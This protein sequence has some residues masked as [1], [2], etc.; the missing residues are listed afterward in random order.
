MKPLLKLEKIS[1]VYTTNNTVA[2]GLRNIDLEFNI[3]EFVTITGSSGSGKTTL[4]NVISGIDTYEEGEL[5]FEGNST[6]HFTQQE[7]EKY[8]IENISFIFQDYNILDSFTVLENVEF[9]LLHIE[10]P[11][12][13]RKKAVELIK[14]VGLYSHLNHKGSKLSGGQKQRTVI[15][16]AL[17]K[18][19]PIILADEPTG[20]LDSKSAKEIVQLLKDISDEKLVIVVTHNAEQ[21]SDVATR[22]IRLFDGSV[23]DDEEYV[24]IEPRECIKIEQPKLKSTFLSG[25]LLGIKRFKSRPKFTT[26]IV[27]MLFVAIFFSFL[28][29]ASE[30]YDVSSS[31]NIFNH[32]DG[33]VV[34]AKTDG[35][36]I[37]KEDLE[38]ISNIKDYV[39]DDNVLELKT[40][41]RFMDQALD[42]NNYYSFTCNYDYTGRI[43]KGRIPQNDNEVFLCVP[44]VCKD[45]CEQ[46]LNKTI[47]IDNFSFTLVGFKTYVDNTKDGYIY[48]T[49]QGFNDMSI[50][51]AINKIYYNVDTY[52]S[53]SS[54]NA[55]KP[56]LSL[57][58]TEVKYLQVD[59]SLNK[60]EI[61]VPNKF[62]IISVEDTSYEFN[63]NSKTI[64]I[65]FD[66]VIK[67]DVEEIYISLEDAYE[68]YENN[69]DLFKNTQ[70]SIFYKNDLEAKQHLQELV[71][72]GYV[73]IMSNSTQKTQNYLT[74]I[75]SIFSIIGLIVV[76]LFIVV[77]MNLCTRR[78][79]ETMKKDIAIFRSMGINRKVISIS[80]YF[81]LLFSGFISILC[82]V[83]VY[84]IAYFTKLSLYVYYLPIQYYLL[85]V[86]CI[87]F[88]VMML[89]IKFNKKLFAESIKNNLKRVS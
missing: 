12:E 19:S 84:F 76:L 33:R 36:I 65:N 30:N 82:L 8:R 41:L 79:V 43:T 3:G 31:K 45:V 58:W 74:L 75:T 32:V 81:Q 66:T 29:C 39:L 7:W 34:I 9:A 18:E 38:K 62:N 24:K 59:P 67:S 17:A 37:Y 40:Q 87:V 53:L 42:Y 51:K 21:F 83:P 15:A 73:P 20:N 63:L 4:L 27:L 6:S 52:S 86:A 72:L 23:V 13:R 50:T 60:G 64:S 71:D 16:R 69:Y 89:S 14:K 49:R 28:I 44:L 61:L 10:N 5:Y 46:Y 55:N 80:T 57:C 35:S 68:I 2:I 88:I 85:V 25:C 70:A 54:S 78:S 77:F 1:K 26:F 22:N 56:Y 48:L 11:I 47:Q